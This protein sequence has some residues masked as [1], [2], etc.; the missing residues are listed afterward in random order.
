[1][2]VGLDD[3]VDG[4]EGAVRGARGVCDGEVVEELEGGDGGGVGGRWGRWR[5]EG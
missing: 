3:E 4:P 5:G 1:M 2:A